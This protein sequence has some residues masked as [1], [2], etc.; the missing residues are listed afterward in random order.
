VKPEQVRQLEALILDIG[1]MTARRQGYSR[2]AAATLVRLSDSGPTRLTELAVAE[3]VT[4]PSMSS[5]VARLADRGLVERSRDPQDARVVLLS[6]TAAGERFVAQR[7]ADRAE[8]LDQAL[9]ALSP[10]DVGRIA[11]A[12]P[13]LTRLADA[14]RRPSTRPEVNR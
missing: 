2:T 7:R 3:G 9:G 10:S 11:D 13:A 4:Q 5:L 14:L 12:L 1:S 8:R 6:L